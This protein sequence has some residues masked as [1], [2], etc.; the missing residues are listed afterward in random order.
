MTWNDDED[1]DGADVDDDDGDNDKDGNNDED[2]DHDVF[3]PRLSKLKKRGGMLLLMYS[4]M[5]EGE[6]DHVA[7]RQ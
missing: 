1:D 3:R 7:S 5:V 2:D 6:P 4:Q